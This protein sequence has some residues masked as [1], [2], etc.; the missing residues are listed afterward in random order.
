MYENQDLSRNIEWNMHYSGLNGHCWPT[1]I[2]LQA[3]LNRTL[4]NSAKC[5]SLQTGAGS[6]IQILLADKLSRF[7]ESTGPA[8]H[9]AFRETHYAI[10]D[11]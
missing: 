8:I 3:R 1:R 5:T 4:F 9:M 10:V 11:V 7:R 2:I 6:S